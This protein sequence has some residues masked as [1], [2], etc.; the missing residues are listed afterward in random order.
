MTDIDDILVICAFYVTDHQKLLCVPTVNNKKTVTPQQ[1]TNELKLGY[2]P[3]G[4]TL[5]FLPIY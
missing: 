5:L 1:S 3:R 2:F 4:K